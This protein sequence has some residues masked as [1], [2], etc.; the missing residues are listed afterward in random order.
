MKFV[1]RNDGRI[2]LRALSEIREKLNAPTLTA[3]GIRKWLKTAKRKKVSSDKKGTNLIPVEEVAAKTLDLMFEETARL[4]LKRA[5][6]DE[7]I[8]DASAKDLVTSAAIAVDKM[9]LLRN[10]PTEIIQVLP[11]LVKLLE[12]QG[13]SAADVFH[14]ML[15]RAKAKAEQNVDH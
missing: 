14:R 10:L 3:P 2:D 1:L 6:D 4:F 5:T 9:R 8:D 7:K 15:E 13:V 11:E 12:L